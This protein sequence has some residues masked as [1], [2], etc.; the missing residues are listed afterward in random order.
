MLSPSVGKGQC[1]V[2][3]RLIRIFIPQWMRGK[4]CLLDSSCCESNKIT[5]T[6][7]L[8]ST[9]IR[10]FV[11][12]FQKEMC[13]SSQLHSSDHQPVPD[14]SGLMVSWLK[15]SC[16]VFHMRMSH[17]TLQTIPVIGFGSQPEVSVEQYFRGHLVLLPLEGGGGK[18]AEVLT[19]LEVSSQDP[20][21]IHRQLPPHP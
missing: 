3:I 21:Y 11:F 9:L 4:S 6:Q 20:E 5:S 8:L 2:S 13:W 10:S 19:P 1:N 12:R 16:L 18:M 7:F 17:H 14:V 15:H